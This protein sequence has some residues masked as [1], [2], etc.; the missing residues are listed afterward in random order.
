MTGRTDESGGQGGVAAAGADLQDATAGL[1]ASG[2]EHVGPQ[3]GR[4]DGAGGG[5]VG[6]VAGGDD[7][8]GIGGD[9]G[10]LGGEGVPGHGAHGTVDCGG[11]DVPGGGEPVGRPAAQGGGL[12]EVRGGRCGHVGPFGRAGHTWSETVGAEGRGTVA[13]G[14]YWAA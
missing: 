6:T 3:P 7:V 14:A 4:G 9:E 13:V 2:F 11:A 10:D 1:D 12:V 5:A 8:V